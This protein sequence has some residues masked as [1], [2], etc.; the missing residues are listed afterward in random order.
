MSTCARVFTFA[1][2]GT[3][4]KRQPT[5][6]EGSEASEESMDEDS[7]GTEGEDVLDDD[8]DDEQSEDEGKDD[9]DDEFDSEDDDE[10]AVEGKASIEN[11]EVEEEEWG[12]IGE[13]T[14]TSPDSS[15][16]K[17]TDAVPGKHI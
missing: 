12:G 8:L 9:D 13:A 11:G 5:E 4:S 3:Q 7:G 17:S 1:Y 10:A 14:T 16:T 15:A 2:L 6:D